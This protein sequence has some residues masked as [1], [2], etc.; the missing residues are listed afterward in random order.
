MTTT[1]AVA[2][3]L[4]ASSEPYIPGEGAKRSSITQDV[5]LQRKERSFEE[6]LELLLPVYLLPFIF[7]DKEG[8]C[9][10]CVLLTVL[11]LTGRLLPP[12][13]A[14]M[15][16]IVILSVGGIYSAERLAA[17]YMGPRVLTASLLFAIAFLG[18]ETTVFLRLSL[19]ALRRYALR[20]QPL[21]LY[22]HLLVFAL[23]LL[24]P[25]ALVVVFST[26]FIDR[27]VT[28]VHNE[29]TADQRSSV[30]RIQTASSSLNYLDE[31]RRPRWAGLGRRGSAA[32][33]RP[34]SVSVVS[35]MTL[36]SDASSSL[37]RQYR[38][39]PP[40]L[41]LEQPTVA[42]PSGDEKRIPRKTSFGTFERAAPHDPQWPHHL[43]V[44]HIR[45]FSSCP[46]PP[47]SIL[48][49]SPAVPPPT[50]LGSATPCPQ[51][52][53]VPSP[54]AAIAG[55]EDRRAALFAEPLST[56]LSARSPSPSSDDLVQEGPIDSPG[57]PESLVYTPLS[58]TLSSPTTPPRAPL[59]SV[60]TSPE[61]ALDACG[62]YECNATAAATPSR[63]QNCTDAAAPVAG[64]SSSKGLKGR[65]ER[66]PSPRKTR[67]KTAAPRRSQGQEIPS[68]EKTAVDNLEARNRHQ[69]LSA[70]SV[71]QPDQPARETLEMK[72]DARTNSLRTPKPNVKTV[73]DPKIQPE[74]VPVAPPKSGVKLDTKTEE[75]R[76]ECRVDQEL[77]PR[78]VEVRGV[79][80][81]R[82]PSLQPSAASRSGS[83]PYGRLLSPSENDDNGHMAH[84]PLPTTDLTGAELQT[85]SLRVRALTS[86]ARPAFIAGAA[87]A[88][89]FGNLA[90]FSTLPTRGTVLVTLGCSDDDC[91]V[92]WWRW[93][94]VSLPVA[95]ICCIISWTFIYCAS[96][97]SCDDEIDEQTHED[98]SKCARARQRNMK[99]HTIREA[100]L[101]YWLIGIP[102]VSSAYATRYPEGYAE[103]PYLGLTLLVLSVA[104][105]STWRRCW[106]LRL[107]C[108]RNLCSRMPW[109][110]ILTLG[111]VMALAKAVEEYRLVEAGLAKLD[112][113]FWTQRSTKAS[114]FILVSV[115]AVLSELVVGDSLAR[116]MAAT[117]VRVA[118]ATETPV[119]FYV[120]PVSLAASINVMLPVSLPL[121]IMRQY[122][123]TKC[124]QMVAYGVFLKC[125]AVV[126]IF[127]S[128]NTVGLILFQGDPPARTQAMFALR[129]ASDVEATTM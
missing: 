35:E 58:S 95:V 11:C 7:G 30:V 46:K 16:P 8:T 96:L 82:N 19:H 81:K 31:G 60:A 65:G 94:A 122:L 21:F 50:P 28:T 53:P 106:S 90:S 25:S 112:D 18:D 34:R 123:Q 27:F 64:I 114:Q 109:N 111:S 87:Y 117:V 79:L 49:R 124:A 118:V 101:F 15:L 61:A 39:H 54:C 99:K 75:P 71:R 121:L 43:P 70:S 24:L 48:K 32:G 44:R 98:M 38:M 22:M 102:V 2:Q 100:L 89:I 41:F 69:T 23:G 108:W 40:A 55:K 74:F 80:K 119:S 20:M 116:S 4:P 51:S 84:C 47:S 45:S 9:I 120:V 5:D 26:V 14:A 68:P 125:A 126:V 37:V 85:S 67:A 56:P 83:V 128:M 78:T 86:A 52:S 113:H 107:L 63:Q 33:R 88:A 10:Y 77:E 59:C 91:P 6:C 73:P 97:V 93:L 92:N 104:P 12:A 1:G 105:S 103:G 17:E 110:V 76:P 72:A 36:A 115:A 62:A 66:S 29:I 42:T 13:V 129:N 3:T 57:S 127:I